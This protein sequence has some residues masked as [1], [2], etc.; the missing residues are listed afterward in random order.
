MNYSLQNLDDNQNHSRNTISIH[1]SFSTDGAKLGRSQNSKHM[2][3][4]VSILMNI[5]IWHKE[6]EFLV[7][8]PIPFLLVCDRE[9]ID[10]N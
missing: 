3:V 1:L 7:R 8:K 10:T 4:L 6:K 5:N 9:N 2:S